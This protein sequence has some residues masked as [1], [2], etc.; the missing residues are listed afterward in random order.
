MKNRMKEYRA[1][2]NLTQS[3]LAASAGL[4][5]VTIRKLETDGKLQRHLGYRSK[6]SL[7]LRKNRGRAENARR[8]KDT[9]ARCG[10]FA[11]IAFVRTN[12]TC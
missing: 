6:T 12:A 2:H 10:V 5:P 1:K 11:S 8:A 9:A 7:R 3:K 4:H